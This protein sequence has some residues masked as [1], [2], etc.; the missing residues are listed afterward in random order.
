M[1]A[2]KTTYKIPKNPEID[3]ISIYLPFDD[4]ELVSRKTDLPSKKL[5]KIY[6]S[7]VHINGT[8]ELDERNSTIENV[9]FDNRTVQMIIQ[10]FNDLK[11]SNVNYGNIGL[12]PETSDGYE[13][14]GSEYLTV[15]KF[16]DY[17]KSENRNQIIENITKK[18]S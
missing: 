9:H 16:F 17:L 14:S 1:G 11:K 5:I 4:I 10:K 18:Q 2:F 13:Y 12:Y 6:Q 8:L 15:E 3:R 7:K